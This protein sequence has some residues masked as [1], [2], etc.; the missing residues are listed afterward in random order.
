MKDK[1]KILIIILILVFNFIN[2]FIP[3]NYKKIYK[4]SEYEIVEKYDKKNKTYYFEINNGN[5]FYLA[6]NHRY[7]KKKKLINSIKKIN[8]ANGYCLLP[9]SSI[10]KLYPLCLVNNNYISYHL[11]PELNEKISKKYYNKVILKNDSYASL[12]INYLDNK[13]FLLWNYSSFY[14]FNDSVQK[15]INLLKN[16]YYQIDLAAQVNNYL[17]IPNYDQGSMFNE[18]YIVNMINGKFEKWKLNEDISIESRIIGVHNKSIF[19]V[20][21]K[22]KVMYEFVPHKKKMRKVRGKIFEGDHFEKYDINTIINNNMVFQNSNYYDYE[23]KNNELYQI[24]NGNK[25]LI[26]N[27]KIKSIVTY[28]EDTVYYIIDDT[29]YMYNS[30]YGNVKLVRNFEW[31]FNYKNLI[32]IY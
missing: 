7:L 15:E 1:L 16:D 18:A 12:D 8:V 11:V 20:D 28:S 22:N 29:L 23:I 19:L 32:F 5:N 21:E 9:E 13:N 2:Y 25:I 17:F 14:F 6:L 10:L 26:N 4:I 27:K 31:E 30:Y 3:N 24:I